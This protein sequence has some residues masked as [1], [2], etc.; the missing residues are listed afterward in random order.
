MLRPGADLLHFNARE[1]A[2]RRRPV[3][4]WVLMAVL[5]VA[6]VWVGRELLFMTPYL[7]DRGRMFREVTKQLE[8][9]DSG[10]PALER[11]NHYQRVINQLQRVVERSPLNAEAHLLLG[12]AYWLRSRVEE[13]PRLRAVLV[14]KGIA[15]LRKGY[16]LAPQSRWGEGR[17]ILG[18]LYYE[19]GPDW[20]FEALAEYRQAKRMR[21]VP[22]GMERTMARILLEKGEYGQAYKAWQAVF[23]SEKDAE[24]YSALG[25]AAYGLG[26]AD[27]AEQYLNEA[28]EIYRT[29]PPGQEPA[30]P[31]FLVRSYFWLGRMYHDKRI[32]DVAEGH[33]VRALQLAPQDPQVLTALAELYREIRNVGKAREMENRLAQLRKAAEA[34]KRPPRKRR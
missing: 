6:A 11:K 2:R 3:L 10:L 4:R 18:E 33:Y 21:H 16:A 5:A 24:V 7:S 8:S 25:M 29:A 12:K 15:A 28:I 27:Q 14:G 19:R 9:V 17:Y 1:R 26:K 32:Y 20:Y 31:R 30:D 23:A 13:D 34:G 22:P